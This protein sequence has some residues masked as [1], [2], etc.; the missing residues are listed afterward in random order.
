MK[1]HIILFTITLLVI[2]NSLTFNVHATSA[3]TELQNTCANF[4]KKYDVIS[5]YPDGSL[6][7]N[8]YLTRAEF[9]TLIIRLMNY[10]TS[11]DTKNYSLDFQD[12]KSTH[13]AYNNLKIAV[14][15][16]LISGYLDKTFRPNNKVNYAEALTIIINALGYSKSLTG[17]WPDN[18]L[19]MSKTLNI[20][21]NLTLDKSTSLTRG[22]ICILLYDALTVNFNNY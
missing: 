14:N 17:T 7:L 15:K 8:N 19:T 10:D 22:E 13:W 12:I 20:T 4:L 9:T 1:K 3:N 18:V 11:I 6:K 2:S 5:G 21:K 16:N